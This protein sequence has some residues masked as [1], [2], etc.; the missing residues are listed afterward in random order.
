MASEYVPAWVRVLE[1]CGYPDQVVVLDFESYFDDQYKITTMSTPEY[2]TDKRWE[3]LALSHTSVSAM[4]PYADYS[5]ACEVGELP[6]L[7]YLLYLQKTYGKDLAGCTVVMQ[8][9]SF[10]ATVL[11]LQYG[12]WPK[13]IIDTKSLALAWNT[14]TK[15]DLGAQ[16][17]RWNLP[18]KLKSDT[19]SFTGCTL[20]RGRYLPISG[21]GKKRKPPEPRPLM[22]DDQIRAMIA[23]ANNDVAR[24]WELFT[25]LLPRLSNPQV[26]LR[27]QQH[28][29]GLFTK[30]VL[31]ADRTLGLDLIQKMTAEPQA[32]LT[33]L[34]LTDEEISGNISFDR[35][36][37]TALEAAG[38]QPMRYC[39]A[40]KAGMVFGLAK[41]D[42]EL[43]A[44]KAHPSEQVRKLVEAR[45]AAKSWPLHAARVE[46]ILAMAAACGGLMPVPLNY[47]GAHTGRWTGGQGVNLQNLPWKGHLLVKALRNLLISDEG[48]ILVLVDLSGIEARV[49]AWIAGQWDLV[50]KFAN[51]EEI[52]CGFAS[53]VLGW[54]VRKARKDDPAPVVARYKWAR[55]NIGKIGVL[56]C[57]YGMGAKEPGDETGT[58][59]NYY[60]A[61]AGLDLAM[62]QRIVSVYRESN[63]QIT[64]FWRAIEKAFAYTAKYHK[65][66]V[67]ERGLRFSSSEEIDV[68]ITLPNG[69]ELHYHKVRLTPGKFCDK[70]AVYHETEHRW[71]YLWGGTITENVVQAMSRDVLIE[72]GLRLEDRGYHTAHHI[73]DELV[74]AVPEEKAQEC[75]NAA[76]EEMSKTPM[77]AIGLPLGAEGGISKFYRKL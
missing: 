12:I 58:K 48:Q 69:R 72:A 28:T 61:G 45:S 30:P 14:R 17:E 47:W 18:A 15:N 42:P 41:D 66:C 74:L 37:T 26:E 20:R 52:Y 13:Y 19:K 7:G 60:F 77:W 1:D 36:L 25:I 39:K 43:A 70:I 44:L 50:Q 16:A 6:I 23:Y 11:A 56:G 63:T 59:P 24:E 2:V 71:E 65:P 22:T 76:V 38:D 31:R 53:K 40:M 67:M 57:G 46:K 32:L 27:I 49:L 73:H 68:I 10:D 9:A 51:K 34:G 54:N 29:L 5:G 55:D 33:E 35:L 64:G 3:A 8:N 4:L 21:R 62:S 75:L